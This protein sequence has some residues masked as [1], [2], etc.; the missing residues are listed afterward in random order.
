LPSCSTTER[1][2]VLSNSL[3]SYTENLHTG[4]VRM[5]FVLVATLLAAFIV[6]GRWL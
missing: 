4:L 2:T 1:V 6:F 5:P 3:S